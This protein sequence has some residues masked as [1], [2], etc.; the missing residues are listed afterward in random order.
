[1][2]KKRLGRPPK[3][4]TERKDVDL[5]IPVTADQ[6]A[7]IMSAAQTEGADMAVWVRPILLLAAKLAVAA[8]A[9]NRRG[10]MFSAEFLRHLESMWP[11]GRGQ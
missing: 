4:Q 7:L 9:E 1:M 8:N 3:K 2:A 6:K 11:P 10:A 5:R